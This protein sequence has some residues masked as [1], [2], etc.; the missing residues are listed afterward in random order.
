MDKIIQQIDDNFIPGEIFDISVSNVAT[1]AFSDTDVEGP[2]L[3]YLGIGRHPYINEIG[4]E[5]YVAGES[6]LTGA[7]DE[8]KTLTYTLKPFLSFSAELINMYTAD[9]TAEQLSRYKLYF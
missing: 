1:N 4:V 7:A 6:N 2:E 5:A 9:Y 8:D 3:E